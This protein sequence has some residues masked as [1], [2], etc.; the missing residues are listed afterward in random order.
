MSHTALNDI[1]CTN[2]IGGG[3]ASSCKGHLVVSTGRSRAHRTYT[4][5]GNF[6]GGR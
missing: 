3:V 6:Y 1:G 5:N 2:P 4:C